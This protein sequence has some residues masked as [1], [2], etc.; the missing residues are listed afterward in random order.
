MFDY[1]AQSS[2]I[3]RRVERAVF[4]KLLAADKNLLLQVVN[5]LTQQLEESFLCRQQST[6]RS[7]IERTAKLLV[8]L[9]LRLGKTTSS[10]VILDEFS[11]QELA[12]CLGA[13]RPKV[14]MALRQLAMRS[15]ITSKRCGLLIHNLDEL[16]EFISAYRQIAEGKQKHC[17]RVANTTLTD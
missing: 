9:S 5:V 12:E 11:H 16:V 7:L 4:E 1:V 15:L 2:A 14:T 17:L 10:G 13:S 3:V 8:D 6:T